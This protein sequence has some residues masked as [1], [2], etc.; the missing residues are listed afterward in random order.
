M[1]II[2]LYDLVTD[3]E[4]MEI[5]R[6]SKMCCFRL[7]IVNIKEENKDCIVQ[8]SEIKQENYLPILSVQ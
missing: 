6:T 5:D 8:K 4:E 7:K 1:A 2:Q 3:K